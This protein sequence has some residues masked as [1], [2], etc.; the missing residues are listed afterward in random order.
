MA[1][2]KLMCVQPVRLCSDVY[3]EILL[4]P[5][6]DG[7]SKAS[8]QGRD[9]GASWLKG[10]SGHQR[11][12]YS[13]KSLLSDEERVISNELLKQDLADNRFWVKGEYDLSECLALQNT[14]YDFVFDFRFF[15]LVI[16][17][18][19]HFEV[20][21][22]LFHQ[23]LEQP[24]GN[25][26]GAD[27]YNTLRNLMVRET[28]Q[29]QI[30]KWAES[31]HQQAIDSIKQLI[32]K[33][34]LAKSESDQAAK[35]G[36]NTGNIT[37][38]FDESPLNTELKAK[39]LACNDRAERNQGSKTNVRDDD[40]VCYAFFGR[41][42]TIITKDPQY[43]RRFAPLQF[44]VQYMWFY[45]SFFV[46]QME[47]LNNTLSV[48]HDRKQLDDLRHAIDEYINKIELLNMNNENL[49]IAIESDS[50]SYQR[51]AQ[52]W[53]VP[54]S[55]ANA[56]SYVSYFKDYLERSFNR[57]AELS[58]RRQNHILFFISCIQLLGIVSI[59]G[60]Y[61]GLA[62]KPKFTAETGLVADSTS[63][64]IL[65]LNTWMPIGLFSITL[66]LLIWV[67]AFRGR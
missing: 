37:F 53:N 21:D 26:E 9:F 50:E 66:C 5:A 67:Y 41:F 2:F 60:D 7:F 19:L 18:E 63:S 57:K 4:H 52:K 25:D 3:K 22:S 10:F 34:C 51:I 17:F 30:S 6:K 46:E 27:L 39:L 28:K 36:S 24:I 14:T 31:I 40:H 49:K 38:F 35:I 47:K 16:V 61:L 55:I 13:Y 65:T 64:F 11:K 48:N 23:I 45:V 32:P 12:F 54:Q 29:S 8:K 43:Y 58:D 56:K 59:W 42:H 1:K 62:K 15:S 20:E 33:R 44:H